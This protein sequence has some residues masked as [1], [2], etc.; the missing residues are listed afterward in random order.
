VLVEP[1]HGGLFG[2]VR[3]GRLLPGLLLALDDVE[4]DV[5]DCAFQ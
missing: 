4:L 1:A 5:P 3:F 2:A